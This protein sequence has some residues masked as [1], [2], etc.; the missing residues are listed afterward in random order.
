MEPT[1]NHKN[2][3]TFQKEFEALYLEHRDMVLQAA[4][5]TIGIK[6]DAEDILQTVFLGL[7]KRLI[8]RPELQ[9]NFCRNP[10]AYLYQS[11]MN[12]AIDF[13]NARQRQNELEQELETLQIAP[14]SLESPLHLDK[15]RVRAAIKNLKQDYIETLS[16]HYYDGYTCLEI[17]KMRRKPLGTV[18][19]DLFRGRAALRKALKFQ[20]EE[21][22]TQKKKH[23][24]NRSP[25]VTETSE[26]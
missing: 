20:E 11:A 8:N 24:G 10:R 19:S 9:S 13:Y 4:F 1:E 23:E 25:I 26:A 3:E 18:L 14:P 22:E 17:S 15:E 12:K 16:L 5:R 6:E 7:F 21:S 2:N